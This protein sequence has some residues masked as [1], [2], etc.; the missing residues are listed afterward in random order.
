[1]KNIDT[2]DWEALKSLIESLQMAQKMGFSSQSSPIDVLLEAAIDLT[3][4]L[5]S[6]LQDADHAFGRSR[7][8]DIK[9]LDLAKPDALGNSKSIKIPF[10]KFDYWDPELGVFVKTQLASFF[11]LLR[12]RKFSA[13]KNLIQGWKAKKDKREEPKVRREPR[14]VLLAVKQ[15]KRNFYRLRRRDK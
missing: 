14:S 8:P 6:A 4:L 7:N 15:Q 1:M 5:G 9:F 11:V 10:G 2:L 13:A 3:L 12:N